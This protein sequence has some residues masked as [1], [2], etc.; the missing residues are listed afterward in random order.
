MRGK[1]NYKNH[2]FLPFTDAT[3]GAETYKG[4]RYIDLE[5]S[6]ESIIVIDLNKAYNPY[7]AY[8]DGYS[9]P[10]PPQEN[11]LRVKILEGIKKPRK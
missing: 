3:G 9:C 11:N 1:E 7:C 8:A 2:L 6:E 4:G 10:V 5:I